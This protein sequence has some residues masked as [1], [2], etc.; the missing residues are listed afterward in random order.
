MSTIETRMFSRWV[1]RTSP[2]AFFLLVALFATAL[3]VQP[4]LGETKS[5]AR[6]EDEGE[7][8]DEDYD[9]D[10]GEDRD[11]GRGKSKPSVKTLHQIKNLMT[12]YAYGADAIGRND[13]AGGIEIFEQCLADDWSITIPGVVTIPG[14]I[15]WAAAVDGAF[16]STGVQ[17][18]QHLIGTV[19]CEVRGRK[20]TMTAYAVVHIS[21]PN[22][23][24]NVQV[25]T[26]TN[27]VCRRDGRW[28]ITA[29]TLETTMVANDIGAPV[30]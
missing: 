28:W 19:H 23:V 15:N 18:T 17:S 13:L 9:E 2:R 1:L 26:Y 3:A 25:L 22:G 7:D 10:R 4:S 11:E 5:S 6:A 16:R 24:V 12:C 20:G 30:M 8:R 21:E 14:A 29:S 27:E